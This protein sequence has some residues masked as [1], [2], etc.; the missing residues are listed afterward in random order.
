[1][2]GIGLKDFIVIREMMK[3]FEIG[4]REE[5]VIDFADELSENIEIIENSNDVLLISNILC[6]FARDLNYSTPDEVFK[7]F[8]LA[9]IKDI[10]QFA[11]EKENQ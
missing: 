8:E 1:M 6:S 10:L 2:E 11:R 3:D 7:D 5:G 9:A 4:S